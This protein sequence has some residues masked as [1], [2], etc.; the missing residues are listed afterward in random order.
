MSAR[1]TPLRAPAFSSGATA[2]SRS[3]KTESAAEARAFPAISRFEAGTAR[4]GGEALTYLLRK[5]STGSPRVE[6]SEE[7]KAEIQARQYIGC[8]LLLEKKKKRI[9][10]DHFVMHN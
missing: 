6:R 9:L 2:S 4:R 3:R 8:R 1:T 10:I 5:G 7:D